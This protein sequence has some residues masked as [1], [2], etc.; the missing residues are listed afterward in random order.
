MNY[1]QAPPF[2]VQIEL[3][4]GCNLR[5]SFCG[6][7]GIRGKNN[8][9]KFMKIKTLVS[10]TNQI[11]ELGWNPRIEFAMHGEPS[12]HPYL[13]TFLRAVRARLPKHHMMMT[14]NGGGFLK[15]I[16]LID[17]CLESLN[18]LALDNYENVNIIPRVLSKYDGPHKPIFY[19]ENKEGN[20]HQ[21]RKPHVH[22]LVVVKDISLATEGTHSSINN[23][24]GCGAPKNSSAQGKRCAKPFRELSVRWDGTIAVCCND[25]R[26]KYR[27]G[28]LNKRK[29]NDI[30]QGEEFVAARKKL[31]HGMRDFSPCEGCDALSYRTSFLPDQKGKE[32][33]PEPSERDLKVIKHL[34]RV[35]SLTLPVYRDYE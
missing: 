1:V 15:D 10:L 35:T 18:V 14:S 23:H 32:T 25:W 20:P 3:V 4:E 17:K 12:F 8:D 24:A 33:L 5:C 30:W 2:A 6:L 19:P 27:C 22:C 9:F 29:L 13:A 34:D 16:S 26:G 11:K 31:Y 28:D 7:N 21:R